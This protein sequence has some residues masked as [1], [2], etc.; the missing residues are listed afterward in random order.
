M[1]QAML[2]AAAICG[3]VLI[4][5]FLVLGA[6]VAAAMWVSLVPLRLIARRQRRLDGDERMR[7]LLLRI[8]GK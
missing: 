1:G 3:L 4:G 6:I 2:R 7:Q 8:E 5:A